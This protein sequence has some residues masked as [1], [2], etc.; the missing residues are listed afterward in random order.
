[1]A[2]E[3]AA[4]ST[5]SRSTPLTKMRGMS[6]QLSLKYARRIVAGEHVA[7]VQDDQ[8]HSVSDEQRGDERRE[9]REHVVAPREGREK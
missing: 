5:V 7:D 8:R 2:S 1:M 9:L 4:I 3:M 6:A